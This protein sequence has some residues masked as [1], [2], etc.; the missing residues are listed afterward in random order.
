MFDRIALKA[1]MAQQCISIRDLA[2]RSSV[3]YDT[4]SK[5]LNTGRE[6]NIATI[7]K[8]A[9]ALNVSPKDLMKEG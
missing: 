4:L 9:A 6:P 1:A 8:L 5:I 3:G 2:N 7:G